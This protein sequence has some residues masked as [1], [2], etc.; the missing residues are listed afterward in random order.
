MYNPV[1]EKGEIKMKTERQMVGAGAGSGG[2]V[3]QTC[4]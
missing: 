3:I 2:T 4:R 1:E